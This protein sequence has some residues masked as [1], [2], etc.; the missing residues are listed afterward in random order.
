MK[1]EDNTKKNTADQDTEQGTQDRQVS[2]RLD[3]SVW[4]KLN[5]ICKVERRSLASQSALIVEKY[6]LEN[7][8]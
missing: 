8:K 1:N 3:L 7:T 4:N 5:E 2:F 6:V